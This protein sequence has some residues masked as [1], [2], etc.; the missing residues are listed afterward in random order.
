MRLPTDAI[1]P[2]VPAAYFDDSTTPHFPSDRKGIVAFTL[3]FNQKAV[4]EITEAT[5]EQVL[6]AVT[7]AAEAS[8]R[9]FGDWLIANSK[10][11]S[12]VPTFSYPDA[13]REFHEKNVLD[14]GTWVPAGS[15]PTEKLELLSRR[16]AEIIADLAT[17]RAAKTNEA[18]AE[19]LAMIMS[20]R[21]RS[22][23]GYEDAMMILVQFVDPMDLTGDFTANLRSSSK[24]VADT[25][26]HLILKKSRADV[27]LLKDA[28]ETKARF[29]EPSILTD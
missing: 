24:G 16:A 4:R 25:N 22:E 9:P 3:V 27:A 11:K 19:A 2:P 8:C 10:M 26:S 18:R 6:R 14:E 17:V 21:G 7:A 1:V 28:G 20:G 13:R 5:P 29:A 12:G 23:L 15:R